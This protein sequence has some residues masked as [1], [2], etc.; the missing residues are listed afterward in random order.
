L[1]FATRKLADR[2]FGFF[3]HAHS[4]ECRVDLLLLFAGILAPAFFFGH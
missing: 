2:T 1:Q 3:A 4:V